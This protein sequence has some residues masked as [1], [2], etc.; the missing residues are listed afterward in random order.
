[1]G[2]LWTGSVCLGPRGEATQGDRVDGSFLTEPA[3]ERSSAG[4]ASRCL[5]QDSHGWVRGG[6]SSDPAQ[7][8]G[9]PASHGDP[10]AASR[11]GPLL[12]EMEWR[13]R[14]VDAE[15]IPRAEPHG[16]I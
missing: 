11:R 12:P 6:C 2:S 5:G 8:P 13:W 14:Q 16:E 1:M 3:V 7:F 10:G 15:A 9:K 4:L